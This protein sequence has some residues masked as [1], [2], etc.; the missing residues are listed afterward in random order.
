MRPKRPCAYPGCPELVDYG[1]CEH[2]RQQSVREYD[3][4][5]DDK[6]TKFYKS[7]AWRR[8]RLQAL[9]RDHGLCQHCL[10]EQRV[11]LAVTVHHVVEIRRDWS[12]RLTLSNLLSLCLACHNKTHGGKSDE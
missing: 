8:T 9:T 5:R 10:K 7:E 3:R 11:T 6:I 4:N 2:H 1:Y 12:K